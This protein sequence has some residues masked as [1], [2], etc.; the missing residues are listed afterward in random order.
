MKKIKVSDEIIQEAKNIIDGVY[1]PLAGFLSKDDLVSVLNKMRLADG[2]IWPMPI[3]LDID[4]ETAREIKNERK[5]I[6]TDGKEEVLM[7]NI[8]V[9]KFRKGDLAKKL[10]GTDDRNHPGV[11]KAM[12]LKEYFAGGAVTPPEI[13]SGF[14]KHGLYKTPEEIREI[15]KRNKWEHVV[16]FQT[17][18][19]PHRSHEHL[20]KE[21]LKNVDGLFIN[22][23]IGPKKKGDF[24][25]EHII[26]AYEILLEKHYPAGKYLMATLHTFMRYAGPKEALFHALIRRNFG[27]THMIIGRDHAG[28]GDYYGPYDA[29]KIFDNFSKEELGIEIMKFENA[30]YCN[31]CNDMVI[32][33]EC[34]HNHEEKAHISGTKLRENLLNNLPV[35][36]KL[37]R[38]EII[39]YLISNKEDLFVL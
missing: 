32:G 35:S 8:S 27:C 17:R 28:V 33:D 20:Q 24:K 29:Q 26:R 13:N 38:R 25:D 23:V 1:S 6:I 34:G 10:F 36:D 11:D 14:K 19:P 12:K 16:A 2:Q 31:A 3:I 18:N 30:T 21:A 9:Y 5:I 4:K 7:D 37:M 15:F 39:D 22:P